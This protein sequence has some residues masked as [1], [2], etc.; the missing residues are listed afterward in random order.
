MFWVVII[1]VCAIIG[2]CLDSTIGKIVIGSSV[3]AI[4][5]LLLR[6]ITGISFLVT[7]AKGCAILIVVT[8]VGG[9]LLAIIG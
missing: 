1:I 8:I 2:A 9:L 5:F 4:G 6:W 7:L 3:L